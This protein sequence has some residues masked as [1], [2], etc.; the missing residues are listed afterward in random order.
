MASAFVLRIAGRLVGQ[1][2]PLEGGAW[3]GSE[4]RSAEV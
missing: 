3:V 4:L 1:G 2:S